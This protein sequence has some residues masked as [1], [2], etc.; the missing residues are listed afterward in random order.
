MITVVNTSYRAPV[1][2][3][4]C[5]RSFHSRDFQIVYILKSMEWRMND[6]FLWLRLGPIISLI[7]A[8]WKWQRLTP[9]CI[10]ILLSLADN[11]KVTKT[12]AAGGRSVRLSC[13][14][15]YC[16]SFSLVYLVIDFKTNRYKIVFRATFSKVVTQFDVSIRGDRKW[17]K[18][19]LKLRDPGGFLECVCAVT[20]LCSETSRCKQC[21]WVIL[22]LISLLWVFP[23]ASVSLP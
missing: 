19:R 23:L 9:S 15:V 17:S 5:I 8:P 1:T 12:G 3:A 22:I 6:G 2:T 7:F 13:R 16:P 18:F 21:G 20:L 4:E 14:F 11:L 10:S